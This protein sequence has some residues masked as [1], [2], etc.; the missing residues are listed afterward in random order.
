MIIYYFYALKKKQKSYKNLIKRDTMSVHI[1]RYKN[2]IYNKCQDYKT[3]GNIFLCIA[4]Y[5]HFKYHVTFDHMIMRL[6]DN[7]YC[8]MWRSS[9]LGLYYTIC[10]TALLLIGFQHFKYS[11]E[12]KEFVIIS[13]GSSIFGDGAWVSQNIRWEKHNYILKCKNPNR[14]RTWPYSLTEKINFRDWNGSSWKSLFMC[15]CNECV[16]TPLQLFRVN[17]ET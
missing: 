6:L 8:E 14:H 17:R 2:W 12:N 15:T 13:C 3:N 7:L 4:G 5:V 1:E 10:I 11:E 9:L 16:R